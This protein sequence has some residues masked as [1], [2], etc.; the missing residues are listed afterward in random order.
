M[1]SEEENFSSS[2]FSDHNETKPEIISGKMCFRLETEMAHC[3][4]QL[5]LKTKIQTESL[6]F[7]KDH[8]NENIKY[9]KL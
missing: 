1:E 3:I 6:E 4:K 2:L 5:W 7:L 8:K 9:Q